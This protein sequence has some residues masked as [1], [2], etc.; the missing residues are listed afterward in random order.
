[1][2]ILAISALTVPGK[3]IRKDFR[4]I[5]LNNQQREVLNQAKEKYDYKKTK[6]V[7]TFVKRSFDVIGG[8]IGLILTAP[9]VLAGAAAVKLESKGPAIF[10]QKRIGKDGKP[11]LLKKLRTMYNNTSNDHHNVTAPNDERIT[12]TGKFLRKYSI[13]E[14]PQF[15]NIIKGDMSLVGPRPLL[16]HEQEAT[17]DFPEFVERYVVKPGAKLEYTKDGMRDLHTRF[18][19]EKEYIENWNLKNDFKIFTKIVKDVLY[20]RNY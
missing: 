1:M 10:T 9:V 11:F 7:S 4:K 19:V 13:D 20:G 2:S 6:P 18:S 12:K 15:I 14:F 8:V 16:A 17:K 3:S 5:K